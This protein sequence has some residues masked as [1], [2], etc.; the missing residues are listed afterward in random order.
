MKHTVPNMKKNHLEI[1]RQEQTNQETSHIQCNK[2]FHEKEY[3]PF[4]SLKF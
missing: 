1:M 3:E 2:Q 4:I